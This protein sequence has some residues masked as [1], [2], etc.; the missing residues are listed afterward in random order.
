MNLNPFEAIGGFVA[1]LITTRV[2]EK[3]VKLGISVFI[4]SYVTGLGVWGIGILSGAG[5]L[6]SCA[7]AAVAVSSVTITLW[8][9]YGKEIPI[10]WTGGVE[11]ERTKILEKESIVSHGGNK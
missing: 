8:I 1:K 7:M 5:F 2:I 6:N 3:Y 4:S 9:K 10:A 11:A